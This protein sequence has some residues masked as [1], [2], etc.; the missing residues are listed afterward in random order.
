MKKVRSYKEYVCKLKEQFGRCEA[1]PDNKDIKSF[2]VHNNLFFDWL[3][4]PSDVKEDINNL[5]LNTNYNDHYSRATQTEYLRNRRRRIVSTY[6]DYVNILYKTFG[7][8]E[9]MPDSTQ[10]YQFIEDYKLMRDWGITYKD[11]SKDL[12]AFIDGKYEEMLKDSVHVYNNR[13]VVHTKPKAVWHTFKSVFPI[14]SYYECNIPLDI[15][16]NKTKKTKIHQN[17]NF[18]KTA[19]IKSGVKTKSEIK[20]NYFIDGDNNLP[21]GQKGI[22]R[23]TKD[24]AV[25]AY[26]SQMGAK[27]KFDEKYNGR[28]NVSSMY[29]KPGDQAVDKQIKKDADR[30]LKK[31]DQAVT[32]VSHDKGFV[33]YEN[34][35]NSEG[36]G[37]H[38]SVAKSVKEGM[39]KR[40]K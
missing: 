11:V 5:I 28:P 9:T 25:K 1:M 6:K 2:I 23:L 3:I 24:K 40:R 39:R 33:E 7:I 14:P 13:P 21:V 10:I 34:S 35:K 12:Q 8:P 22:E 20:E 32:I 15:P 16:E 30:L 19:N 4:E 17:S 36:Y 18:Y 27:R 29:V 26:F 37:N 38:I 31:G